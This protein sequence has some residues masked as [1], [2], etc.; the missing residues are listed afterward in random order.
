MTEFYYLSSSSGVVWAKMILGGL[1]RGEMASWLKKGC[2][3]GRVCYSKR[4]GGNCTNS[5]NL[6]IFDIPI[7]F[8]RFWREFGSLSI[9]ISRVL[10]GMCESRMSCPVNLKE[11]LEWAPRP[12]SLGLSD[13]DLM[14]LD[15]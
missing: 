9:D 14:R 5:P 10:L 15:N 1:R 6:A 13:L 11:F 2:S 8:F 12:G 3:D 7:G 4:S